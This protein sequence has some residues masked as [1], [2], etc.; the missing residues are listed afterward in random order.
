MLWSKKSSNFNI[1]LLWQSFKSTLWT[2]KVLH[3]LYG[4][5]TQLIE[6]STYL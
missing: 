6:P 5:K 3:D 2:L 1:L 4:Q